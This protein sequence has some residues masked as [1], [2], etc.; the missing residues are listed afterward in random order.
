MHTELSEPE[1]LRFGIADADRIAFDLEK[2]ALAFD[3]YSF[4]QAAWPIIEPSQPFIPNW[5][6]KAI[7]KVLQDIGL[8]LEP[9]DRW[10]FNIPPG[11][12]KSILISVMWPAWMWARDP[13]KRFLTASYGLHLTVRDNLRV[14]DIIQSKWF[15]SRWPFKLVE[16]QNTKTRFNT[17]ERGWRIA[18]SVDGVGTGEHPDYIIID[19]PLTASQAESDT[20]RTA[21]NDWFD[22]TLSSRGMTRGVVVIVVMQRLHMEDLSGH[23]LKRGNAQHVCFPMRYEAY[24]PKKDGDAGHIPD[25]RDVRRTPG[26]LL[27]PALIP[28]AKVAKLEGDLL[29]Y[30]TAGQLQQRPAPEGGGKFKRAWFKIVDAAPATLRRIARGWDTAA[31]EG[32]GDYTVGVKMAEYEAGKFIVLDVVRDQLTPAGVDALMLNTTRMDGVRVSQREEREGGASGKTVIDARAKALKGF[33]YAGVPVSKSKIA[34][35]KPFRSQCEAGNVCLLLAGW[36][37]KYLDELANFPTGDHDD[38]VDGSSA[39]FNALL[40]EEPELPGKLTW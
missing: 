19:D 36:N 6:I 24:R 21:C 20:E 23:I 10:V 4:V 12:L 32:A 26:E 33:D 35:S 40:L 3:F 17:D 15:Q 2:H 5:H 25:P 27:F 31:T 7:C 1:L 13:Q 29:A 16:D 22:R 30:G 8:G 9:A 28:E 37:E 39:S 18:T 34:R 38:Q 11:T 14:R